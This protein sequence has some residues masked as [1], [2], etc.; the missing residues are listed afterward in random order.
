MGRLQRFIPENEDGILVEI[1]CR[2]VG[3]QALLVPSP[4]PR[5][6][7]EVVV[8]VMGRA[9]EV[10]PLE[11]C[12]VVVLGNHVHQLLVV[13]TQQE[14]TRYMQHFGCN[15]TKEVNRLRRRTGS[16]WS[17][18]YDAIVVSGEPEAQWS[19]LRYLL[20]NSVKEG[21][22]SS[23]MDWPGVHAARALV[24]GE[25]L[26]GFWFNRSKEW[27]ARSQDRDYG[28]YD[29]AT[30]YRVGL[31]Q[32]PAFR[33][34]SPNAYQN[35]V[36]ELILEIEEEGELL[37]GGL[38]VA[39]VEKILSQNPFESPTR[40]PKRSPRP[41]FHAR[42]REARK[43]L[44]DELRAF[45]ARYHEA[46]E[47]L[48][49]GPLPLTASRFPEGCYPPALPFVGE[50][51]PPCPPAPTTRH[52]EELESGIVLRGEIPVVELPVTVFVEARARGQPP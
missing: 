35:R 6:F 12:V 45:L 3:G 34:L 15:L 23:P 22:C 28:T 49:S 13:H 33:D 14:L 27:A 43:A 20:S 52:I 44:W 18:R 30:E 26:E 24:H 21:L 46:S 48:H 42:S 9:L 2:T 1:T 37:R 19:R 29:F 40:Q 31:A 51:P 39:G 50:P 36:A 16:M 10:S 47:E 38:P 17:R 8:G 7:N 11:V 25:K 5:L 32:L 41:V 4:N